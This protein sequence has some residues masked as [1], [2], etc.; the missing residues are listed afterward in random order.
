M[1]KHSLVMQVSDP[2]V[3]KET[4]ESRFSGF[5][6]RDLLPIKTNVRSGNYRFAANGGI[7]V[8]S[9]YACALKREIVPS[10]IELRRPPI[11]QDSR[12]LRMNS[13]SRR[14]QAVYKG[15]PLPHLFGG[16]QTEGR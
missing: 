6:E 15:T 13:P 5:S 7:G 4:F 12:G 3:A 8:L 10:E 11:P 1:F 14:T 16:F 2:I 9:T